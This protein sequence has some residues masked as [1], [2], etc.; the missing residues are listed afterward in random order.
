MQT[1][2]NK[3]SK[4]L[5]TVKRLAVAR[6]RRGGVGEMGEGDKSLKKKIHLCCSMCLD[7][8]LYRVNK[9]PFR[10]ELFGLFLSLMT[11]K[12]LANIK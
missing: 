12:I 10:L 9:F 6:G 11:K 2:N 5:D 8:S 4:L 1:N 3:K 7:F